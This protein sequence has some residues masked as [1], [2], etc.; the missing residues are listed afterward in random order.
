MGLTPEELSS[1]RFIEAIHPDSR[2]Q[3][4]NHWERVINGQPH[5]T[6][7]RLNKRYEDFD[8]DEKLEV[9][10]LVALCTAHW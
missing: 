6:E 10:I 1:T 7:L 3:A 4:Q 2:P 5:R 8:Q 9:C